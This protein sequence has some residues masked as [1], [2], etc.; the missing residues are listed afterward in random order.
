MGRSREYR[1]YYCSSCNSYSRLYRDDRDGSFRGTC[2][3]CGC[4]LELPAA[5]AE[6]CFFFSGGKR[7]RPIHMWDSYRQGKV[8]AHVDAGTRARLL[9]SKKYKGATWY[10]VRAAGTEG[11]VIG[12]FIRRL[13]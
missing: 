1:G 2:S 8:V 6:E 12:S 11:W 5:Y 10:R 9:E 4:R 3:G 7:F 13:R